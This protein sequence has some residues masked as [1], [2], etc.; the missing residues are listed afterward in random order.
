ML[1]SHMKRTVNPRYID[2]CNLTKDRV[3]NGRQEDL[4]RRVVK[5]MDVQKVYMLKT[6]KVNDREKKINGG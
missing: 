1:Y 5:A 4:K 6:E 3:K 2:R